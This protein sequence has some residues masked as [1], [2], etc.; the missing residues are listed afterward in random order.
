MQLPSLAKKGLPIRLHKKRN[1]VLSIP[2]KNCN[3]ILYFF[4]AV[5]V[6]YMSAIIIGGTMKSNAAVP[7][8]ESSS[9]LLIFYTKKAT[10]QK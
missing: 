8:I 1:A 6:P 10:F 7:R 3:P 4:I 2:C 9:I 5:I